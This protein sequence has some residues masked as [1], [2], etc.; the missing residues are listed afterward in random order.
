MSTRLSGYVRDQIVNALLNHAFSA[1]EADLKNTEAELAKL[2]Y[3]DVYPPALRRTMA[4]LPAGFLPEQNCLSL[5]FDGEYTRLSWGDESQNRRVSHDHSGYRAVAKQYPPKDSLS[6]CF[7]D[8]QA[9]QALLAKDMK[10]AKAKAYG[11]LKSCSTVGALLKR[12][13]EVEPFVP[14]DHTPNLP[15]VPV[16]QLNKTFGLPVGDSGV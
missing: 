12:W 7:F 3:D 5:E 15:A 9:K 4:A 8:L 11:V 2:V 14:G 6:R 10:A 13:P 16:K 1:R